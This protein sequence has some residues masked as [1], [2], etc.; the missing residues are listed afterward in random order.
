MFLDPF[1]NLQ[2]I[3]EFA[4]S[5]VSVA[6]L[7][8][9]FASRWL[10]PL[11]AQLGKFSQLSD[12]RIFGLKIDCKKIDPLWLV[13]VIFLHDAFE[14]ALEAK[15]KGILVGLDESSA[16]CTSNDL[17]N[18]LHLVGQQL[19]DVKDVV[20]WHHYFICPFIHCEP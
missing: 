2:G 6:V 13:N 20:P 19:S 14:P 1:V 8:P 15:P 3:R 12:N 10:G 11:Q 18:K 16:M 5:I 17:I 7:C 9:T 4:L